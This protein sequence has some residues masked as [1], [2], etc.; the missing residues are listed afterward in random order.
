MGAL[1]PVG[2]RS[3][4]DELVAHFREFAPKHCEVIGDDFVREAIRLGFERSAQHGFALRG[5]VRSY[6]EHMFM[7]GS[8]FDT[9]PQVPWAAPLLADS[10]TDEMARAELLYERTRAYLDRAAGPGN[11]YAIDALRAIRA[12]AA[13]SIDVS[14]EAFEEELLA[15]M[16]AM[17]P[18]KCACLGDEPL[19]KLIDD[20]RRGA[21]E[22][23]G[24]TL[25]ARVLVVVLGFALGSGFESD[26]LFPWVSR[27]LEDPR[28][29]DP[30]RRIER[31]EAR[32]LTYLD[33]VLEHFGDRA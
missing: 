27:T 19:R 30:E 24:G 9:D 32:A 29:D 4:E 1:R 20:G 13:Q 7:F 22:L 6:I 18:A 31:L 12:R 10:E 14:A 5:P 17:Y 28:L 33:A 3:Y 25:R 16:K 23:G 8:H 26:P 11:Q 15:E 2:L 21:D